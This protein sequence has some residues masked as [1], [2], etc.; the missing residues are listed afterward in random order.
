MFNV[1]FLGKREDKNTVEQL[2]QQ[3]DALTLNNQRNINNAIDKLS[4]DSSEENIKFL[5]NVAQGLRYG[6]SFDLDDKKTNNDW[7][8]KL[9]A[10]TEKA[11]SNTDSPNKAKL[12]EQFKATFVDKK[13]MSDDEKAIMNLRNKIMQ[14]KGLPQAMN[15]S[16]IDAVKNISKNL[17]YFVISTEITTKEK[18]SCLEKLNKLMSPEYKINSQLKDKKPQVLG[19]LLN[20]LVVKT[21][22]SDKPIIKT[23]NQRHHGMCAA[24]STS[25][26]TMAY[27]YKDKYVTMIMEELNNK[28]EMEVYD[29][30]KLGTGK[31]IS[32]Q[33]TDVD[34][35]Y[36]DDKGYRILDASALQWMN[37]AGNTG[38]GSTQST[39]FS[40]FDKEFFDTFHDARYMR[41]FDDPKL[42]PH[43]NHLRALE[44]AEDF[45]SSARKGI[46]KREKRSR[47][48]KTKCQI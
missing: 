28:P 6:T 15:E 1:S 19:E 24:I 47:R 2:K 35:D 18:K 14:T 22:E 20:D 46:Q 11:L 45:I 13:E 43:Q 40:A 42:V 41:D 39:H 27:E 36:A 21:A 3:G 32:V 31:K 30:T 16:K 4:E 5:M 25:R 8:G 48:T 29:P 33:K 23:T 38:N 34:F 17:D 26:K 44:K 9:K 7:K 10:A 12:Q 37:I